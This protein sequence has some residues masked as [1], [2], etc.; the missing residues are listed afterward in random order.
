MAARRRSKASST[1]GEQGRPPRRSCSGHG[2]EVTDGERRRH[3]MSATFDVGDLAECRLSKAAPAGPRVR[4]DGGEL[5]RQTL[6]AIA[7]GKTKFNEIKQV[8]RLVELRL[9]ERLVP[10]TERGPGGIDR[11][12]PRRAHGRRRFATI[13]G[14]S[15][16]PESSC[17]ASSPSVPIGPSPLTRS[18]SM[19]SPSPGLGEKRSSS[20]RR[21]GRSASTGAASGGT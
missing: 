12:P 2:R 16:R 18:R 7:A 10:V 3:R 1:A 9:V 4:R 15:R 21:S 20:V 6:Y 13:C 5:A 14:V 11:R 17:Q 8:V 19:R